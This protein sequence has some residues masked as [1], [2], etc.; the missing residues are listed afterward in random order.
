MHRVNNYLI[1]LSTISRYLTATNAQGIAQKVA[2]IVAN[3]YALISF[4][5]TPFVKFLPYYTVYMFETQLN[6]TLSYLYISYLGK[7]SSL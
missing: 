1:K 4:I 5:L 2:M 3:R 7:S 6:S